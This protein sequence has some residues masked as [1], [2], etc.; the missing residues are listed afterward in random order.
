MSRSLSVLAQLDN[1]EVILRAE[2][3]GLLHN[4]GKLDPNFLASKASNA[5]DAYQEIQEEGFDIPY[6]R[7]KRFAAPDVDLLSSVK[8]I[9]K[10]EKWSSRVDL[11]EALES[12]ITSLD[13]TGAIQ[14]LIANWNNAKHPF[15]ARVIE[16]AWQF[17]AFLYS[18][19]P[20]Y[21]CLLRKRQ[22]VRA[23][24]EQIDQQLSSISQGQQKVRDQ[25]KIATA[26]QQ[27]IAVRNR[28]NALKQQKQKLES[29]REKIWQQ[30]LC[31]ERTQQMQLEGK[32]RAQCF[33]IAGEKWPLA[34]LLT[35]FW[36]DFFFQPDNNGYKRQSA[37]AYW[38]GPA[39]G[40]ALP[41]LLILSHAE[42]SISEKKGTKARKPPWNAFQIATAF[43]YERRKLSWRE[44]SANRHQLLALALNAFSSPVENRNA[45]VGPA[46]QSLEDGLG[47]T[48]WPINEINLWDYAST[49]ASLFKAA[50][51]KAVIENRFAQLKDVKWRLLSIRYDGLSYLNQA[52]HIADLLAR[53]D[54]L[55][56]ALEE[57]SA[58]IEVQY[59]LGNEVYRDENGAILIVPHVVTEN[60]EAIDLL[61]LPVDERS[62]LESI[63]HK[64][65]GEA[66]KQPLQGEIEP[67]IALSQELHGKELKL[68]K[69]PGWTDPPLHP[70]QEAV[71][72]WWEEEDRQGEV[73]TVCGL[74][75]QGYGAPEAHWR[76]HLKNKHKVGQFP[77]ECEV[78]KAQSRKVCWVCLER[79]E[80]RSKRWARNKLGEQTRTIWTDEVADP[81]GRLALL[82]GRFDLDGWLDGTLVATMQKNASF[83]RIRRCWD[84]TRQFWIEVRDETI[85]ESREHPDGVIAMDQRR[86]RIGGTFRSTSGTRTLG[87]FHAYELNLEGVSLSVVWVPPTETETGHFLSADNLCYIAKQLGAPEQTWSEPEAAATY[88]RGRLQ[89]KDLT[90]KEPSGHGAPGVGRG[91]LQKADPQSESLPLYSPYI[92]ILAEPS[93]FM[94]LVP[95]DHAFE[96]TCRIKAKY[97]EEIGKVRDRLSLHLGLVVAPR[98]TPLRTILEAGRA[99][100]QPPEKDWTKRWEAWEVD[101]IEPVTWDIDRQ[102]ETHRRVTFVNGIEW[103]LPMKMG[104]GKTPDYWYLHLLTRKPQVADKFED[105]PSVHAADLKER[106]YENSNVKQEG[107]KVWVMPSTFDFEFLDV[108]GRRFEIYYDKDGRRPGHPCRPYLLEEV[109]TIEKVWNLISDREKGLTN[110]QINGL[111]E[112]IEKK[113]KD[114]DVTQ[115]LDDTFRQFVYD[116]LQEAWGKNGWKNLGKEG[117][118]LIK[119]STAS[120]MLADV[121]ELYMKIMKQESKKK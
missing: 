113:R 98:H 99:L 115:N 22:E 117:Q 88:V 114:W 77:L 18:N 32:F 72:R 54:L 7:F 112:V 79:R 17:N 70:D 12:Q 2:I 41:A 40:T 80:D 27:K 119:R 57:V 58:I 37:L 8:T 21:R 82:I 109:A 96:V 95:A 89:G 14:A 62:T 42:I 36:D 110:T 93:I 3:A 73:C 35:L 47:D 118:T 31:E 34:D 92:P 26:N 105:K 5:K 94:A 74:R 55:Q 108:A 65:F 29:Q 71:A 100:L 1:R 44:Y 83:A 63:L 75:P 102:A 16:A 69:A 15:M 33:D 50:V 19:G 23:K 91:I 24:Q 78:C 67:L 60:G 52:Y 90:V 61:K 76:A 56:A 53:R 97:E 39:H 101:S 20:L 6:Y 84:T 68:Y 9:I 10:R 51:A 13:D 86:L 107:T 45:F 59:P 66:G 46:K 104:D 120:G 49:I 38:L 43:G 87:P 64:R 121:V 48:Q 111:L 28:L 103:N 4:I 85:P 81:N 106:I 30:V 11:A 25:L 116:A